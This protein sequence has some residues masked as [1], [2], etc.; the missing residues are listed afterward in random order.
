MSCRRPATCVVGSATCSSSCSVPILATNG[1]FVVNCAG[2]AAKVY[3]GLPYVVFS[4]FAASSGL[5]IFPF[6]MGSSM[7]GVLGVR[8]SVRVSCITVFVDMAELVNSARGQC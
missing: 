4:S 7:V 6:G 3:S 8:D 2:R 5:I 1:S